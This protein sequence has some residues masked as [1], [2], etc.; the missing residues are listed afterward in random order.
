MF[1]LKLDGLWLLAVHNVEPDL[2]HHRC[3]DGD[4]VAVEREILYLVL[5][6]PVAD[7]L[8]MA[9]IAET[10]VHRRL[11]VGYLAYAALKLTAHIRG[12]NQSE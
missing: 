4:M 1:G 5:R 9:Q 7:T 10:T 11:R 8:Q 6:Y 12:A 2:A 3:L